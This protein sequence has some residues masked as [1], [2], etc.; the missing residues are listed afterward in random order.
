MGTLYKRGGVWWVKF[1]RGG[2]PFYE[3]SESPK[4][5]V[6]ERLLKT[7]EGQV[8]DGRFVGTQADKLRFEDLAKNIANDYRV[9]DRRSLSDMLRKVRCL[10]AA[11]GGRRAVD[12][13]T[14]DVRAY[15]AQRQAAY[16]VPP[17]KTHAED[18][19][20]SKCNR[21]TAPATIMN[22]L[23][24]LKRMFSLARQ[25]GELFHVPYIPRVKVDNAR[26]GFLGE[27]EYLAMREALPD[28]LR[29]VL[30]FGYETSWRKQEI[31]GLTWDRVDLRAGTVRLDTSKND[32]GRLVA[33]TD[34]LRATLQTLRDRTAALEAATGTRVPWVFHRNGR[35]IR[36][37]QTAWEHA[38]VTAGLPSL[39]FHDLRRTGVRN[40]VRAGIPE[41]VAMTISGHKTR[42][43]FDRYNIVSEGDL[44]EAAEKLQRYLRSASDCNHS[45][46][47]ATQNSP[48]PPNVNQE[49]E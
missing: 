33:L 48:I 10:T 42:S 22:E 29:P 38:R 19:R 31:L 32:A 1:Y 35:R 46:T 25:A 41:R 44:R 40:M 23:A 26:K 2:K 4:K 34:G 39:V 30:D 20:C 17:C 28:P 43:I 8:V 7:R 21:K 36:N 27:I 9:N 6:A 37:F 14:T 11:F 49:N 12:I 15:I 45:V 16:A 18:Q 13:T 5:T 47:V 3:S 24:A